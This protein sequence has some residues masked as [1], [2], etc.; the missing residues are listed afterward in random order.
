MATKVYCDFTSGDIHEAC[1]TVRSRTIKKSTIS[2][3]K[4]LDSCAEHVG[5]IA[6]KLAKGAIHNP[7]FCDV[8]IE[9]INNDREE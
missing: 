1:F 8:I 7:E 2:T 3:L 4:A 9:R 5:D 6:A